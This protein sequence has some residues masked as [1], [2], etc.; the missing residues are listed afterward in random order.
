[1]V[2]WA[3]LYRLPHH[4]VTI[5][6]NGESYRR[7][8]VPEQAKVVKSREAEPIRSTVGRC[9]MLQTQLWTYWNRHPK[10]FS[11]WDSLSAQDRKELEESARG[12]Y[13]KDLKYVRERLTEIETIHVQSAPV[14]VMDD[15]SARA[16]GGRVLSVAGYVWSLEEWKKLHKAWRRVLKAVGRRWNYQVSKEIV[17]WSRN[18]AIAT[19]RR[20]NYMLLDQ[21]VSSTLSLSPTHAPWPCCH[22]K[23][24]S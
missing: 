22:C 16:I 1:M 13:T 12:E 11:R 15:A 6:I 5:N 8:G 24:I 18:L 17:R 23:S 3:I 21:D 10:A 4:S 2:T 19:E 20:K 9:E 7:R 14:T